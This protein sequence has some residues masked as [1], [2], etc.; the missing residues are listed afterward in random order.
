MSNITES[1][2]DWISTNVE[3]GENLVG[4]TVHTMGETEDL[5]PP[6]IGI[7]ESGADIYEEGSVVMYGV[8]DYEITVELHTAPLDA[9]EGGTA[10]TTEQAMR[11]ELYGIL[12]N[13]DGIDFITGR[14]EW[15]VFDIRTPAA[16]TETEDDR[17]I[18]RW[19]LNVVAS[20]L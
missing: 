6:F 17:R 20:P 5:S 2:R 1:I 15:Q 12:G 7:Y 19:I 13:R 9:P 8:T 14:E 11:K 18:S 16:I 3:T 4:V 10:T